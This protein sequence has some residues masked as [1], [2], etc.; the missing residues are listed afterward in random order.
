MTSYLHPWDN[1]ELS[2]LGLLLKER[3]CSSMSK[4]FPL[5]E[6][7]NEKENK[8]IVVRVTSPGSIPRLMFFHY[9]SHIP[10]KICIRLHMVFKFL[11]NIL[12]KIN[13]TG[14]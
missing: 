10:E 2:E 7:M 11:F 3:I 6:T 1:E 9:S 13:F 5:K 12:M 14:N 8:F 4:F